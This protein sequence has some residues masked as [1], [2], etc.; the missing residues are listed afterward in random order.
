MVVVQEPLPHAHVVTD[1]V[2]VSP[3]LAA[4]A[5]LNTVAV[6]QSKTAAINLFIVIP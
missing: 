5:G 6:K 1:V 4:H 2:C 3:S